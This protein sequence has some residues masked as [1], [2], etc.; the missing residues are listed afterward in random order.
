LTCT[1]THTHASTTTSGAVARSALGRGEEEL[2]AGASAVNKEEYKG[3]LQQP[4]VKKELVHEATILQETVDGTSLGTSSKKRCHPTKLCYSTC[5]MLENDKS[6][7]M[8][9]SARV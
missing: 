1:Y 7:T 2:G 8:S 3:T 6:S 4:L 9:L 5:I